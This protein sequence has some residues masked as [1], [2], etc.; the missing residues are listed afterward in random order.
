MKNKLKNLALLSLFLLP[1]CLFSCRPEGVRM[2]K[3]VL[4]DK[5][6]GGWAGQTIGVIYGAPTEFKYNGVRI[7]DS[8][9]IGWEK[10]AC[11]WYFDHNGGIYDDLYMDLTFVEAFDRYG[12]DIPADTLAQ[13]FARAGYKLWHAN[14]AARYNI[15][16]GISAPES[17]Y[18]KNNPHAD[19]IDFQI[20]ADFAG[21]MAPGM[22]VAATEI[23]DKVGHI[24]CYGDGWYGGVYVAA[25]YS[26]AFLS[27]D[28]E[29]VVEEALKTIPEASNYHR[30]IS[31]V[32]AWCRENPDWKTTWQLVQDQWADEINCPI[33]TKD[34]FNIDAKVNSAYVVMGLLYGRKDLY[35][36]VDIATRCGADSDCNPA[37]AAGILCTML[38]YSNIPEEW[39]DNVR[40]VEALN[41]DYT[42]ISLHKAY[43]MSLRHALQMI[44]RQGGE[45]NKK[46]VT[47]RTQP[48][49]PVRLE[50]SFENLELAGK[51]DTPYK[52]FRKPYNY[53][54][55]GTGIALKGKL[56]VRKNCPQTYVARLKIDIDGKEEIVVLPADFTKRKVD[57]YWNYD[58]APGR[59]TMTMQWLNAIPEAEIS[60]ESALVYRTID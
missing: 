29:Y 55:D 20:E 44:E 3:E 40:E 9:Y 4:L 23:C 26:L 60:L 18:W 19:D 39:M 45:V 33:G 5:I 8:V 54:F 34:P 32:I 50:Q 36:T 6:K 21:L 31:D 42:D 56:N 59:H 51:F 12:F 7:P 28:M 14:Q 46:T 48:P 13:A 27:D 35:K 37:T 25:L 15:L 17:G 1:S 24:M 2:S 43:E 49:V 30:C 22:P 38:G 41:F 53:M 52:N 10:G 47:I 16:H 11:K 57:L 58:L